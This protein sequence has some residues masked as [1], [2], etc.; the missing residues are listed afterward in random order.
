MVS[1]LKA[2]GDNGEGMGGEEEE[3]KNFR[4]VGDIG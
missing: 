2:L 4:R 3:I 1:R